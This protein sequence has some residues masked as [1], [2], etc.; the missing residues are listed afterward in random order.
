MMNRTFP[1][2]DDMEPETVGS[3]LACYFGQTW[4]RR[5]VAGGEASLAVIVAAVEEQRE[6]DEPT[7]Q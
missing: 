6:R 7:L 5:M 1:V 3:S 2:S 4:F